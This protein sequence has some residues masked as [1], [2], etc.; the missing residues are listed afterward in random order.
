MV[1]EQD[2]EKATAVVQLRL[3]KDVLNVDFDD[4]CQ[5]VGGDAEDDMM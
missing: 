3:S 2:R 5:Y 1:V 4:I